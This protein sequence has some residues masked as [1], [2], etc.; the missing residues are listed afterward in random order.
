MKSTVL[1]AIAVMAL[2]LLAGGSQSGRAQDAAK[3]KA[4]KVKLHYTG[5]GTVDG[6]HKILVFL[7][8]SPDF[9]HGGVVPFASESATS[10]DGAA[11]FTGV[12]PSPVYVS[13]VYDPS[14]QYDGQSPPPS[15]ASLGMYST[16]PGEPA[17][18]KLED[19]K[20]VE[21]DLAFDDSAKMP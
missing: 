3:G 2:G 11:T 15:G 4:L 14:G 9:I 18:V 5:S 7:F 16:N 13:S 10:K 20:T 19:G 17:A 1:A 6:K 8:D 21:I 12:S